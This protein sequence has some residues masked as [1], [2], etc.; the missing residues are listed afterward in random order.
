MAFSQ[1]M[2]KSPAASVRTGPT[3][4]ER[5][6]A[7]ETAP[8]CTFT[9]AI[10]TVTRSSSGSGSDYGIALQPIHNGLNKRNQT[11]FLLSFPKPL[12]APLAPPVK[13]HP[14]RP[15]DLVSPPLA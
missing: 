6:N 14:R 13:R 12:C 9:T 8:C 4:R 11:V 3:A 15:S 1:Q 7:E 10:I 5:V 2:Q